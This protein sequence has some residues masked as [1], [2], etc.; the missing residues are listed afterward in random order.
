MDNLADFEPRR[1]H[2]PKFSDSAGRGDIDAELRQERIIIKFFGRALQALG[3][4][5]GVLESARYAGVRLV[6]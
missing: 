4:V 5:M 2:M 1:P 3:Q 6:S